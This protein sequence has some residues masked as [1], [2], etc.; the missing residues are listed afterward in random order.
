MY[1]FFFPRFSG[2]VGTLIKY[3]VAFRACINE[4]G[5]ITD[6]DDLFTSP[7]ITSEQTC[8]IMKYDDYTHLFWSVTGGWLQENATWYFLTCSRMISVALFS[9]SGLA[10][11]LSASFSHRSSF[12]MSPSSCLWH[13]W[14]S[15]RTS[16]PFSR[17]LF[18]LVY[19]VRISVEHVTRWN[20]YHCPYQ[21][22]PS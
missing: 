4:V 7:P 1:L 21:L 6:K 19:L 18:R 10:N 2:C 16:T 8:N 20:K 14:A 22:H 12:T 15:C 5:L 9:W 3:F 11:M 17:N 13:T